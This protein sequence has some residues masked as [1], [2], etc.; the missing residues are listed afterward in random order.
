MWITYHVF[1]CNAF[2]RKHSIWLL[3]IYNNKYV[4]VRVCISICLQHTLTTS[5]FKDVNRIIVYITFI[6]LYNK[7]YKLLRKWMSVFMLLHSNRSVQMLLFINFTSHCAFSSISLFTTNTNT[8][9]HTLR[10]KKSERHTQSIYLFIILSVLFL[11]CH[12]LHNCPIKAN[13]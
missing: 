7:P 9:T 13:L 2:F 1:A 5:I 12:R 11:L 3:H 10:S 4:C 6:F 8:H